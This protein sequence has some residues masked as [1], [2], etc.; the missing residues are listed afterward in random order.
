MT[1]LPNVGDDIVMY[2]VRHTVLATRIH[3]QFGPG[4]QVEHEDSIDPRTGERIWFRPELITNVI[5]K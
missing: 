2:G 1:D 3:P 5:P 4:F